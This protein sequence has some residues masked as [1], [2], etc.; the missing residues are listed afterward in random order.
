MGRWGRGQVR[1]HPP[2][3][4]RVPQS[5]GPTVGRTFPR[6]G[7]WGVDSP[8]LWDTG[9]EVDLGKDRSSSPLSLGR[10]LV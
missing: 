10:A 7:T 5:P 3:S 6:V 4:S 2:P 8:D 9:T 1:R